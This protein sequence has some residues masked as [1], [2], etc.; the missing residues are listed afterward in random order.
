MDFST[1]S[2]LQE[3]CDVKQPMLFNYRNINPNFIE[4]LNDDTIADL[5]GSLELKIKEINDYWSSENSVD[6]FVLPLNSFETLV[7]TDT[8]SRYFTEN[9]NDFIEDAGLID[10]FYSNNDFLKPTLTLITKYDIMFGST[11]LTT[12]LRYHTNYRHFICVNSGKVSV[13][14]TPYKS[15]KYLNPIND[16]ETYE[17]R[18]PINV[19][20]PQEKYKNE[21]NKLKFLEFT[22]NSGNIIYVPP[23]WWYSIKFNNEDVLLTSFTYN[24]IMNCVANSFNYSRYYL[25]QNN[26]KNKIMKKMDISIENNDEST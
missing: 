9:N 15:T 22:V 10:L 4:K 21:I 16:Y 12:P 2:N 6:F 3:V 20:K 26:I 18:S 8:K 5:G 1:N 14:M 23:Y 19:W 7:S 11:G 24:S 25:Q 13:K 17:F